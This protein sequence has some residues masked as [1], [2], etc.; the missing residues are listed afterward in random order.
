MS[1]ENDKIVK[2][3]QKNEFNLIEHHAVVLS[4]EQNIERKEEVLAQ[5]ERLLEEVQVRC[6]TLNS[7]IAEQL[8]HL[9]REITRN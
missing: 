7:Q 8:E 4:Y 5:K 2:R 9:L 1:A 6:E 3:I